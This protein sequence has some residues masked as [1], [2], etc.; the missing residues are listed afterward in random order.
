[1]TP[2]LLTYHHHEFP[3]DLH[4]QAVSFMRIEWPWI[5][6]GLLRETYGAALH[7]T[8]FAIADDGLLLSYAAVIRMQVEHM[9][10]TYKMYGL[11]TVLT[12]PT[13][14]GKGYGVQVVGA[15]TRFIESSDAD[16]AA[17]FCQP[18][19]AG[20]YARHGW[21][22]MTGSATLTGAGDAPAEHDA[23]RMMLFV[24][25]KGKAGRQSFR[26]QPL[27]VPHGW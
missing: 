26:T 2:Q 12:Y 21:E 14:R 6:G 7:P 27:S 11:G 16:V 25:D 22:A 13:S 3:S 4:W 20:F 15:A 8:H 19:L 5:E 17:L 23:L 24:S 18:S 9:A 10:E 1:M